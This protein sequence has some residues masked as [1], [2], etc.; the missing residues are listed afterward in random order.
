MASQFRLREATEE[1]DDFVRELRRRNYMVNAPIMRI[2]GYTREEVIEALD[3]W[4]ERSLSEMGRYEN[5]RTVIAETEE[6]E[7]V[8]YAIS[9]WPTQDDF[10][11]LPQGYIYD[12]GV[13]R[14]HWGTGVAAMLL[15]DAERDIKERG[16]AFVALTVNAQNGRAVEFYRKLGYLEEWKVM[17]KNLYLSD[18]TSPDDGDETR[19]ADQPEE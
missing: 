5:V 16:G 9:L 19:D 3:M 17:G 4:T 14:K 7:S 2:A 8:G 1:D 11:Q 15:E 13:H 10:S 12:I 18:G 6:G